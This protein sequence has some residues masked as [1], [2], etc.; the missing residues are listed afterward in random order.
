MNEPEME[1]WSA[2]HTHEI[3]PEVNDEMGL[4]RKN[5]TRIFSEGVPTKMSYPATARV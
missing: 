5:P 1:E 4:L 3:P 2:K